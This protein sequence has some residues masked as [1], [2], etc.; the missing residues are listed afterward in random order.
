M[1]LELSEAGIDVRC[2]QKGN[3]GS[4][5]FPLCG[6]DTGNINIYRI[7]SDNRDDAEALGFKYVGTLP[8]YTDQSCPAPEPDYVKVYQYDNSVQ[9]GDDGIGLYKMAQTLRNAGI[10]VACSQEGHDGLSRIAACGATT[11]NINVYKIPGEVLADA[12]TLGF[13]SINTLSEY[14][15]QPCSEPLADLVKVY[16]YGGSTQC[17]DD[18]VALDAM[19]K[20]LTD[21][22]INV[23]C[24]Q[25]GHDG[26][27]YISMCG[28]ST[29]NI[30]VYKIQGVD[31]VDA[32]TLGFQPVST[33][34][35]Y[36]DQPCTE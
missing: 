6:A 29:G 17:Y 28:A 23:Y 4:F 34:S 31:L 11:G 10:E 35:E 9:C 16:R 32:E 5:R 8:E 13:Q 36:T 7:H 2:A 27:R 12:E 30:N 33:L 15:D 26:L 14:N 1:I 25:E 3:D 22:G 20:D 19:E 18:G 21:A 24:A